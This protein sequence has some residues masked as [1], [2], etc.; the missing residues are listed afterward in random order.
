MCKYITGSAYGLKEPSLKSSSRA[1]MRVPSW[2]PPSTKLESQRILRKV[3]QSRLESLLRLT[4]VWSRSTVFPPAGVRGGAIPPDT[5]AEKWFQPAEMQ[6]KWLEFQPPPTMTTPGSAGPI[7][8]SS[9]KP[10][11]FTE[12][13]REHVSHLYQRL[14]CWSLAVTC[15][16]CNLA[17]EII[18]PCVATKIAVRNIVV[19]ADTSKLRTPS[20]SLKVCFVS[21]KKQITQLFDG[22][23]H[24][25][26]RVGKK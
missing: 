15:N 5:G 26:Q 8:D 4:A 11:E 12:P 3:F 10:Q 14:S 22:L 1:M 18:M 23:F 2:D 13:A 6:W 25:R 9:M 24:V 16:S 21:M 7:T 17:Y 19:G 20:S